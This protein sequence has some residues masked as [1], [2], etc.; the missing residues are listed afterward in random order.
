MQRGR[1]NGDDRLCA[2]EM[3][4]SAWDTLTWVER[5]VFCLKLA[6][7]R[8]PEIARRRGVTRQAVSQAMRSVRRR[9]VRARLSGWVE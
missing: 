5:E 7:W 4:R 6:G 8:L 3:I 1:V 9:I 2:H